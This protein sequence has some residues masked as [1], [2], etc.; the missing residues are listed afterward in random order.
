MNV[1]KINLKKRLKLWYPIADT[2]LTVISHYLVFIASGRTIAQAVSHWIFTGVIS[3][4]V[5]CVVN[6]LTPR[7]VSLR[8]IRISPASI[9]PPLVHINLCIIWSMD[10][11]SVKVPVPQT[12]SHPIA[13]I[14][15]IQ[16]LAYRNGVRH[17]S[18]SVIKVIL[19]CTSFTSNAPRNCH[20]TL[21]RHEL[22]GSLV[23]S[24]RYVQP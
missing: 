5:G 3:V 11:V 1:K 21:R 22:V 16:S 7:Q 14:T 4:H 2:D 18:E 12:R 15:V 24:R 9:V 20:S 19:C 23:H 10:K 8:V 6:I 13:T 17:D